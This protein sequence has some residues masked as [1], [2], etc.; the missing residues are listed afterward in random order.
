MPLLTGVMSITVSAFYKFAAIDDPVK[1]RDQLR[2]ELIARAM[3][4]TLLVAS[5]GIN[6]TISGTPDAMTEFLGVLRADPRFADL[7][8]KDATAE[9]HPFMRLKVKVK[10][11][12]I[13]LGQPEANPLERTGTRVDPRDW[14]ALIADPDVLVIDTR[15]A[16]EVEVGT[17]AGAIDPKIGHF[18]HWPAYVA[19]N[20]DAGQHRKVAMFC[21][22]GIRC[23]KASAYLLAH[24]FNEVYQLDGGILNYLAKISSDESKWQGECFVFDERGAVGRK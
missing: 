2:D 4:G 5:E 24:G 16:Y 8:T 6:G 12:I 15:N 3:K 20:L 19:A 11:E 14:N 9:Q 18:T 23:E 1:L 10:R 7:V 22:G 13:T 17:F 21:T